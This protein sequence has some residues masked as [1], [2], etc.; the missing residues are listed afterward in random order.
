[1]TLLDWLRFA[2]PA[3]LVLVAGGFVYLAISNDA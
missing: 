3:L 2:Y 1:M